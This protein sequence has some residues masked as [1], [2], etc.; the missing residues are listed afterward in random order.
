MCTYVVLHSIKYS[1]DLQILHLFQAVAQQHSKGIFI[2]CT[3]S[4]VHITVFVVNT[5]NC[6]YKK[7]CSASIRNDFI[8]VY[9]LTIQVCNYF[10]FQCCGIFQDKRFLFDR[11]D[12]YTGV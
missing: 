7:K 5:G 10:V 8:F 3:F 6:E 11:H 4:S 2:Y 9:M 12:A 1:V